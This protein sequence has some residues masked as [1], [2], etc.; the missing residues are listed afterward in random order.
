M[1][2]KKKDNSNAWSESGSKDA[3]FTSTWN[4]NNNDPFNTNDSDSSTFFDN[5]EINKINDGEFYDDNN[6]NNNSNNNNNN[7]NDNNYDKQSNNNTNNNNNKDPIITIDGKPVKKIQ[8]SPG[9]LC[10]G[11]GVGK[12]I[13]II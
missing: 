2:N 10:A 1:P 9:L 8:L 11:V 5:D 13:N 4:E 6:S 3:D 12:Y 7:R